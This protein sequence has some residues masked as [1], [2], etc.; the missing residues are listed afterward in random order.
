MAKARNAAR[1]ADTESVRGVASIVA[2]TMGSLQGGRRARSLTAIKLEHLQLSVVEVTVDGTC[3][4]APAVHITFVDEKFADVRGPREAQDIPHDEGYADKLWNNCSFWLYRLLVMR[5]VFDKLDPILHAMVDDELVIRPECQDYFLFCECVPDFWV[6]TAPVSVGTLSDWNRALL[7]AM[8]S[9]PRGF[10]AHRSGFVSCTCILAILDSKG[11]ELPPGVVSIIARLG[12]WSPVSG[13]KTVMSVF[14]RKVIDNHVDP[15]ALSLGYTLS[16]GGWQ[17][18]RNKYLGEVVQ[19]ATPTVDHGRDRMPLQLRMLVWRS[20]AWSR[21]L[22]TLNG[23]GS[24]IFTAARADLHVMPVHRYRQARRAFVLY[25][26][27]HASTP[28]VRQYRELISVRAQHLKDCVAFIKQQCE[29]QF[30]QQFS[31]S[32]SSNQYVYIGHDGQSDVMS[33]LH[34]VHI[35]VVTVEG[36]VLSRDQ[37]CFDDWCK[38]GV[39]LWSVNM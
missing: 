6:D 32:V 37:I 18:R 1:F 13:D 36:Q 23:C 33:L 35:G 30:R 20:S 9:R 10:S 21:F 15:Y 8:G 24:F 12:G 38:A 7:V 22:N 16:L 25:M 14:A 39:C 31:G 19:P 5:G 17:N 3:V 34:P 4:N 11:V 27:L 2:F 28:V 29:L 26:N